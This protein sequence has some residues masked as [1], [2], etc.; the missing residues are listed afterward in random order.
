LAPPPSIAGMARD[1][2]AA[3]KVL[4]K[5]VRQLR[6]AQALTQEQLA[7]RVEARFEW[8]SQ[9]ELAKTNCTIDN[10]QRLAWAFG[11]DPAELLKK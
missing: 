5:N 6:L 11:V 9:I 1:L 7:N 8:I 4:A 2:H 10:L 3:R